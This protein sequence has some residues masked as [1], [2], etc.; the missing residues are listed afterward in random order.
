V[1]I[2]RAIILLLTGFRCHL[3]HVASTLKP[4]AREECQEAVARIVAGNYSLEP[5]VNDG[6]NQGWK[7]S[8][9]RHVPVLVITFG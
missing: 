7:P 5:G 4:A 6:L 2:Q 8:V 3:T 9:C 1:S